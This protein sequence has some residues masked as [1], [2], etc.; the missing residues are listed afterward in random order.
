MKQSLKKSVDNFPTQSGVYLMRDTNGRPVYIGKA[1]N[2]KSRVR[3]Y[4]SNDT[5]FKN[6]F[7][8][9]RVQNI[10]YI[11]TKTE[12]EAF[13]MEAVLVKQHKPRYNVR[14]KDDKSYPYIRCSMEEKFP[15]FH[16]ERKVKKHGSLYFGP[17]TDVGIARRMTRF[18]SEHFK[19]RDCSNHFMKSRTKPCLTYDIGCCTAPC[20]KKVS[21]KRYGLQVKKSLSFLKGQG[22]EV[23]K[24]MEKQMQQL[25]QKEQFES[26]ARLRDRIKAVTFCREKQSVVG[27]KTQNMDVMAFYGNLKEVLFQTL[28]IRAGAVTGHRFYY[29]SN[30]KQ[31]FKKPVGRGSQPHSTPKNL[32]FCNIIWTT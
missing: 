24:D 30:I 21:P 32:L 1:K 11:V 2:L 28:H 10:D 6:T 7:L 3:S 17:Y 12:A 27:A 19:I 22:K 4:F 23:L 16:I 9:P 8:L 5:N 29:E 14:L 26:A 15:R 13:L 31:N 18:L 25:S 20:V